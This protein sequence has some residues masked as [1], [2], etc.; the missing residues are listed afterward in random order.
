MASFHREHSE[1]GGLFTHQG[2]GSFESIFDLTIEDGILDFCADNGTITADSHGTHVAGII[3]GRD[4]TIT[5]VAP[6]A[7]LVIMKTFS[8]VQDT[9]RSAWILAA[10][11]DCVVLGVDVIN[12]SLGTDCGFSREMDKEA[13]SGVY[14][15]I[16]AAGISIVAAASNS[17][18]STYSSEK[19]GN[20]G[21]TSNPDSATVG[22]PS[23]YKGALSVASISGTKTPYLLY[24]ETIIYFLESSDRVSEEK[25]FYDDLLPDGVDEMEIEFITIPG[26]GRSAD[27]TG[28][29]VKGK[30]ALVR[31]G[32]TTFEEKAMIAE[33]QGAAGIIIY[34]NV[35]GR[36]FKCIGLRT[37]NTKTFQIQTI[38]N[39]TFSQGT[40]YS[41]ISLKRING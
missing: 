40:G 11:D 20:L 7:Q 27:Y 3:A 37:N 2:I 30:I 23:T 8:D 25:N 5:G 29:D 1:F 35:S 19:N 16:R 4:D 14:D 15:R 21:L 13:L 38:M 22:S 9:A 10:L 32:D 6:N 18:N 34:N 33:N 28:I 41:Q 17:Y 26:T 31:R 36:I 12:M 24:G 39:L